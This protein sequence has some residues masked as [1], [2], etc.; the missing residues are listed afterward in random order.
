MAGRCR[1]KGLQGGAVP[2]GPAPGA[3][4]TTDDI[5]IV[6]A[7]VFG[8]GAMSARLERFDVTAPIIFLL[9]GLALTHGPLAVLSIVPSRGLVKGLAE[10]TLVLVLFCDASRVRLAALRADLSLYLRLL[11]IGLPL[12]IGLGMLAALALFGTRGIWLALLMGAALAPTDAALGAGVL[13]SPQVPARIRRLLNVESGLN[14]GI[15][16][17]V[18]LVALAGAGTGG[19]GSPLGPG[20]AVAELV[21]GLVVGAAIGGAGG[22][23]V[24][25]A[26]RGGW[27]ADG[28]AGPAVLGLAA[29]AYA[30]ALALHGNGF[31][32]AFVGGLAF[33]N[34]AGQRG[35]R[36]V[37]F[38]EETG[39]VL[40]LLTWLAFG[41][42]AVVPALDSLSWRVA[43][44][45]AASL[46]VIR[47]IPVA[48]AMAH[49]GLRPAA[50]AFVGW[51]GPRGLASVVFAL[52]ALEELGERAASPAVT[53]ITVTVLLSVI[54]HGASAEPLARRYGG[55][56]DPAGM[57]ADPAGMSANPAGMSADPAGA[58]AEIPVR[59]LIRRAGTGQG[60]GPGSGVRP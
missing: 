59:R 2:D 57:S 48:V 46:T 58:T 45:A 51:F 1:E 26:R 28:F 41:A 22:W 16:T 53:V 35:E 19:H 10:A 56:L 9:A 43:L 32:A 5:A 17:P 12:T 33:G 11:G 40:S 60:A 38:V 49:A 36:L 15:V 25:L 13:L 18:V 3:L 39:A 4:M 14:D 44:Y 8:W 50:V 42:V 30:S 7:L 23:L 47:M 31:I 29:C 55:L 21:V 52:L 24:R 6:A 34:T 54:L 37:P 27:A 20:R